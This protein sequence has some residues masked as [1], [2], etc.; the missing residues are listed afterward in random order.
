SDHALALSRHNTSLNGHYSGVDGHEPLTH[1]ENYIVELTNVETLYILR[2]EVNFMYTTIQKWG[3]SHAIR[4]PKGILA[5]VDLH[6]N[7]RVTIDA[8]ND[9]IVIKRLNEGHKTLQ[10]RLAG[11][12][13]DFKCSEWDTGETRGNEVR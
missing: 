9:K 13:G 10:E 1:S 5:A 6:E 7:D 11:Y 2:L 4:L 3:N 12:T 8:D